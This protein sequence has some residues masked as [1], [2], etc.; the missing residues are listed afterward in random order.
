MS[1]SEKE[2]QQHCTQ[3]PNDEQGR[4]RIPADRFGPY[5]DLKSRTA[6]TWFRLKQL[7]LLLK[8]S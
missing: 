3:T 5:M 8:T 2:R 7:Q 4:T 1:Q 6:S